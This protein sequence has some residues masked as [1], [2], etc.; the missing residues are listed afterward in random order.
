[1]VEASRQTARR[2]HPL[3]AKQLQLILSQILMS[4]FK[5]PDPVHQLAV[6]CCIQYGQRRLAC[7]R[8]K[9]PH[10]LNRYPA[11]CHE[12]IGQNAAQSPGFSDQRHY[13]EVVITQ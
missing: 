12:I 7:E 13:K 1:M 10:V 9:Q 3:C 11:P 4:L 6:Q 2:D 8:L 5:L